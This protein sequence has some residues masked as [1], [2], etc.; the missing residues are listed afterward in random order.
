M[1]TFP[2]A[3]LQKVATHAWTGQADYHALEW[4]MKKAISYI[5]KLILN[6]NKSQPRK[7][8]PKV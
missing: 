5:Q 7:L 6:L 2:H 8:S 3:L 1:D 4:M